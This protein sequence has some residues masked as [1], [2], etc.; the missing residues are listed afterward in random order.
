MS[1][2][3][4]SVGRRGYLLD[5]FRESGLFKRIV[6]VNSEPCT[7]FA[8]A[9]YWEIVPPTTEDSFERRL[10]EVVEEQRI[11]LVIPLTDLDSFVISRM[12]PALS[13]AGV[14]FFG[15]GSEKVGLMVDKGTWPQKLAEAGFPVPKSYLSAEAVGEAVESGKLDFPLVVKPRIGTSS[16][17]VEIV[18]DLTELSRKEHAF[19]HHNDRGPFEEVLGIPNNR[20]VVFQEF[21]YGTEYGFDLLAD[22]SGSYQGFLVRE[23]LRMRAGETDMAVTLSKTPVAFS[24]QRLA[25]TLGVVG[26]IDV[27]FVKGPVGP[28]AIIDINPRIGGGYPFSHMAGARLPNYV[29]QWLHG[30]AAGP[31]AGTISERQY[32]KEFSLTEVPI[33]R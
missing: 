17:S 19:I 27:D 30:Q 16:K 21:V 24:M 6:A 5:W 20:R 4:T 18:W 15:P 11:R 12:G 14:R 25:E 2:L 26:L 29:H 32:G 9:S 1:V 31:Q 13:Q 10:L 33:Y 7:G 22:F 28:G 3:F 23:K 8:H